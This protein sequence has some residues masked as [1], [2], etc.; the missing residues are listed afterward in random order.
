ML[1]IYGDVDPSINYS[2]IYIYI[3]IYVYIYIYNIYIYIH[4]WC[5]CVYVYM[6]IL[7]FWV[8]GKMQSTKNVSSL[9]CTD[10]PVCKYI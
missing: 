8:S 10:F 1:L 7:K 5:M 9:P 4:I 3:Y 6:D 2:Y